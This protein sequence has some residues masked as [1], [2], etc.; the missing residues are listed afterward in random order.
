[1][2]SSDLTFSSNLNELMMYG[3]HPDHNGVTFIALSHLEAEMWTIVI[4]S[5]IWCF[6][7]FAMHTYSTQPNTH[8]NVYLLHPLI[9]T[10]LFSL[11]YLN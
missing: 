9:T 3:L 5:K 10:V 4:L 7:F 2:Q 1:M 8:L 11:L 6:E